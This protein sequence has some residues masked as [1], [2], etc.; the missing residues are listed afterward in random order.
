MPVA[1]V[2]FLF[3]GRERKHRQKL[4]VLVAKERGNLNVLCSGVWDLVSI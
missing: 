3:L 2:V 4:F 1:I